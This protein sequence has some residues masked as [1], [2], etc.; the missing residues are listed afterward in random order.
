M[1]RYHTSV[2]ALLRTCV[3]LLVYLVI[4]RMVEATGPVKKD[5]L[6]PAR[7]A[8]QGFMLECPSP[9]DG[10]PEMRR[11]AFMC[12]GLPIPIIAHDQW[13]W[14]DCTAR[15]VRNWIWYR[16]MT[17]DMKTGKEMEQAQK[18]ALLHVLTPDTDLAYVPDRSDPDKNVY[19]CQMWD[20]GR[21]LRALVLWWQSEKEKTIK[22]NLQKRIDKMI[23]GLRGIAER[24]EDPTFGPYAVYP[25]DYIEGDTRGNDICCVRGGQLIEPLATYYGA[26]GRGDVR[27]FLDELYAGVRSGKEGASYDAHYPK[28]FVFGKDGSFNGHFHA[29][30]STAL[31]A[32]RYAHVLHAK[33]DTDK[34]ME[35]VRW[36]KSVYDWTLSPDNVNAGSLWGW[37]PENMGVDNNRVREMSETCCVADMIEFAAILAEAAEWIPDFTVYDALWDHVEKYTFNYILHTQ[38]FITPDYIN[39]LQKVLKQSP[40]LRSGYLEFELD[41]AGCFNHEV[42]GRQTIRR[43]H[44]SVGALSQTFYAVEYADRAASFNYQANHAIEPKGFKVAQPTRIVDGTLSGTVRTEDNLL[45]I[46]S[47]V[48]SGPG[49]Y[50]FRQFDIINTSDQ[51]IDPVH[52]SLIANL[53]TPTWSQETAMLD[54]DTLNVVI[55]SS[56]GKTLVGLAGTPMPTSVALNKA[57]TILG[58][59]PP[60]NDTRQNA[61]EV[62]TGNAAVRCTW[63]IGPLPAGGKRTLVVTMAVAA[64]RD[65]LDQ[66]LRG[67]TFP[68]QIP[69][70]PA[71]PLLDIARKLEGAW[72]SCVQPNEIAALDDAGRP[73]FY[74]GGCCAY[75][76]LR[77]LYAC[78]QPIMADDSETLDIRIP[79]NREHPAARQT[80]A[81]SSEQVVQKIILKADRRV[82]IRIPNWAKLNAVKVSVG[83][84]ILSCKLADRWL[85]A[86]SQNRDTHLIVN[87]PMRQRTMTER[88]GGGGKSIWFSL[89][90]Q[91]RTFKTTWQGNR[92]IAIE[93]AGENMPTFPVRR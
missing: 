22:S 35:M 5:L 63:D 86:G 80:V 28:L 34:A 43:E 25:F 57:E 66:A 55:R 18:A 42:V 3:A 10:H 77:G 31:G 29:H 90:E 11:A 36:A 13:D 51:D 76:G 75:S 16:E 48:T 32:A 38:F 44:Q 91:K 60:F 78:W 37:F 47:T 72:I 61:Q 67:E 87:Y 93:P 69:R 85:D 64:M 56:D 70:D 14:G 68:A 1:L 4:A 8:A 23:I 92:V 73:I 15:A 79:A 21:T 30:V 12:M 2:L 27:R 58:A 20:Q 65:E 40:V 6:T 26:T 7:R 41:P 88:V 59:Q 52:F 53:D 33:G 82:R 45:E 83:G 50:F 71:T 39:T 46:K 81:E 62:F 84:R 49:P 19:H 74:T 9:V 17:G 54:P 89:P 24:G